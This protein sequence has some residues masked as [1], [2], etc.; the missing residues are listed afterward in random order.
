M[1]RVPNV[2]VAPLKKYPKSEQEVY[3]HF[4]NIPKNCIDNFFFK[5][6]EQ[7]FLMIQ[8]KYEIINYIN[9]LV[10]IKLLYLE[11]TPSVE[12]ITLEYRVVVQ[13]EGEYYDRWLSKALRY[14][15]TL[16]NAEHFFMSFT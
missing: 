7:K 1:I 15:H 12:V 3:E 10:S 16:S 8:I 14:D 6:S 9:Y 13:V 4:L 5:R 2:D 11:K